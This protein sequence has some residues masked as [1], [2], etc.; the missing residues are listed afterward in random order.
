M[1]EELESPRGAGVLKFLGN[2]FKYAEGKPLAYQRFLVVL[3]EPNSSLDEAGEVS[4]YSHLERRFGPWARTYAVVC[5]LLTQTARTGTV[6]I[7]AWREGSV[8][9]IEVADRGPGGWQ[10]QVV[11]P[12]S[13]SA[14]TIWRP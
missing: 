5:F 9:V 12:A 1:V 8:T 3:D 6:T 14:C 2:P 4:A 13:Q 11:A 10:H 7:R